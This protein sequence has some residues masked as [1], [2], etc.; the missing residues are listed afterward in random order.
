MCLFGP[1]DILADGQFNMEM[2]EHE[3]VLAQ[4]LSGMDNS[5]HEHFDIWIFWHLLK[6]YGANA[7]MSLC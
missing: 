4:G 3:D 5:A 1:V 6:Q 2:F 7:E